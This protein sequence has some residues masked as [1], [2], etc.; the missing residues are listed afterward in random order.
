M[1]FVLLKQVAFS[2]FHIVGICGNYE[3][4][5]TR[6]GMVKVLGTSRKC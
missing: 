3:I 6:C 1:L 4:V 5:S 2:S